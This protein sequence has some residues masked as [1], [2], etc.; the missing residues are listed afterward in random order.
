MSD[1]KLQILL[2]QY[3][4]SRDPRDAIRFT[5]ASGR[6]IRESASVWIC[7]GVTEDE[8]GNEPGSYI[9]VFANEIDA[10]LC[11]VDWC[12]NRLDSDYFD[13]EDDPEYQKMRQILEEA[14]EKK[15]I[16]QLDK[17]IESFNR[18]LPRHVAI[19]VFRGLIQ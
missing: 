11:A 19:Y 18:D 1:I 9:E 2:Q 7:E 6:E 15:D 13:R 10:L 3:L 14:K 12:L 5:E 16:M 17:L 4:A 8:S